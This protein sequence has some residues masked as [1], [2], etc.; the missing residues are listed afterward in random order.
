MQKY[1]CPQEASWRRRV[2]KTY[3]YKQNFK[4]EH[5]KEKSRC[6]VRMMRG[7]L[8]RLE[9]EKTTLENAKL[10]QVERSV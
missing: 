9:H 2:Y 5:G 10:L 8:W 4:P 1:L 7:S 3:K 6:S